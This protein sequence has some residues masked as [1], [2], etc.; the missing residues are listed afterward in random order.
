MTAA[1][2]MVVGHAV[3]CDLP[4]AASADGREG[5]AA[6]PLHVH[7]APAGKVQLERTRGFFLDLGP[8]GIGDGS[9][10]AMEVIHGGGFL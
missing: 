6:R 10:L 3:S 8:G 7:H 5:G 4:Q 2:V 1:A 9:K